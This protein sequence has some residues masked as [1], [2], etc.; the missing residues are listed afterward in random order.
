MKEEK[1]KEKR[2]AIKLGNGRKNPLRCVGKGEGDYGW[3][4]LWKR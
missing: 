1:Q 2:W 4:D 3:K